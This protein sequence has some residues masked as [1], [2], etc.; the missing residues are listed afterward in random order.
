MR[1]VST[2]FSKW[3]EFAALIN[4]IKS[5]H[6][7]FLSSFL[8]LSFQYHYFVCSPTRCSL[9]VQFQIFAS[10]SDGTGPVLIVDSLSQ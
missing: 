10:R 6:P 3:P 9:A 1:A 4:C 8:W 7:A 2:S 5:I